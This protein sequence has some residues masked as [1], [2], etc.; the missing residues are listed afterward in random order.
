LLEVALPEPVPPPV[1]V[2][3]GDPPVPR[4]PESVRPFDEHAATNNAA[5]VT[6]TPPA[7]RRRDPRSPPIPFAIRVLRDA[8]K[9]DTYIESN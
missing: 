7:I 4:V 2:L 6:P 9:V 5:K 3:L 1:L 8:G